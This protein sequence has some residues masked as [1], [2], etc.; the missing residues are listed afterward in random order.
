MLL[1]LRK[2]CPKWNGN[3]IW[4]Q[5]W[6]DIEIYIC[7]NCSSFKLLYINK[8]VVNLI[9]NSNI[10]PAP[11]HLFTSF[12]T[13]HKKWNVFT[14]V[15]IPSLVFVFVACSATTTINSSTKQTISS[16][17]T[18]ILPIVLQPISFRL[19]ACATIHCAAENVCAPVETKTSSNNMCV[20]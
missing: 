17:K 12:F 5:R 18:W 20:H 2:E 8:W 14:L 10:K 13:Q 6:T 11:I 19:C 16:V 4:W 3:G 7:Q 15:W 9:N 1:K